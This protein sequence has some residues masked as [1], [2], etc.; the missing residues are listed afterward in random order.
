[1]PT[2]FL[3]EWWES[4]V[5]Y[6][7]ETMSPDERV[8]FEAKLARHPELAAA[9]TRLVRALALVDVVAEDV[10]IRAA[11]EE[12]FRRLDD[13]GRSSRAW[14]EKELGVAE[15]VSSQQGR[16]GRALSS[17]RETSLRRGTLRGGLGRQTLRK[18]G[19]AGIV[20]ALAIFAFFGLHKQD[21]N[22][23]DVPRRYV[24]GAGQRLLV[25]LPDGIQVILAPRTTLQL[26]NTTATL[27]GEAFFTVRHHT[28]TP[29]TVRTGLVTT[30]VLGTAFDVTRYPGQQATRVIVMTGKVATGVKI[31]TPL[32]ART[33]AQVTDSTVVVTRTDDVTSL[34]AWTRGTLTFDDV[35]VAEVLASLGRWYGLTFR[36]MDST[37]ATQHLTTTLD[38]RR[39]RSQVFE[40]L[41]S[42]LSVRMTSVGDTVIL[43]PRK[44]LP[45]SA[46]AR[47]PRTPPF[48]LSSEMGR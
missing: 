15:A 33:V 46:P 24:T 45:H 10:T 39:D 32:N 29:F 36:L 43:R 20:G 19:Y 37:L 17:R 44:L 35:P 26:T 48:T 6:A 12:L 18:I 16:F 40:V 25:T 8:T 14:L 28:R 31:M 13:D 4:L 47:R 1:M 41:E 38:T 42:A 9:A 21:S 11:R 27:E 5:D 30:R 2:D 3:I 34:T 7:S 23:I 22:P